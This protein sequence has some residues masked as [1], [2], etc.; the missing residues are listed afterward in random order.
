MEYLNIALDKN[1]SSKETYDIKLQKVT[2][3][4]K[5]KKFDEAIK[6]LETL[7]EEKIVKIFY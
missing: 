5:D 2:Y 4:R 3:L 7:Q 1:I 6:L